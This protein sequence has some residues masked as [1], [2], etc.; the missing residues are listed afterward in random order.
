MPETNTFKSPA[1]AG[2]WPD[3]RNQ[4]HWCCFFYLLIMTPSPSSFSPQ[5]LDSGLPSHTSTIPLLFF[6]ISFWTL[7]WGTESLWTLKSRCRAGSRLT[8]RRPILAPKLQVSKVRGQR[9]RKSSRQFVFP[10]SLYKLHYQRS[11][12]FQLSCG[13]GKVALFLKNAGLRWKKMLP[14]TLCAG[15]NVGFVHEKIIGEHCLNFKTSVYTST[16]AN[17]ECVAAGRPV[18]FVLSVTVVYQTHNG[19]WCVTAASVSQHS[20]SGLSLRLEGASF[21]MANFIYFF[22]Q[23]SS[24]INPFC[25]SPM[26][27]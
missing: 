14:S 18:E 3:L 11:R 6:S 8:E 21:R 22:L 12:P 27:E 26:P 24:A 23:M 20:V 16:T 10:L 15:S 5:D 7:G 2:V 4:T 1:G 17:K 25:R 19:A 13:E 9:E